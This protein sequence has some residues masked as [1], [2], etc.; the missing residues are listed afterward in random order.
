[1]VFWEMKGAFFLWVLQQKHLKTAIYAPLPREH[2]KN[3][4]LSAIMEAGALPKVQGTGWLRPGGG[5]REA[6]YCPGRD[7]GQITKFRRFMK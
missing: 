7:H 1:M 6:V 4:V 5:M 2:L 3:G